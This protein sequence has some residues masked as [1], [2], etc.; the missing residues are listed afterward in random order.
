[1]FYNFALFCV[2]LI[3]SASS[4]TSE[5]A[6]E[7]A[8]WL[9]N[10]IYPSSQVAEFM[11]DTAVHRAQWIRANGT[12]PIHEICREFPR[13]VD[14]SGMVCVLT[15]NI[16]HSFKDLSSYRFDIDWPRPRNNI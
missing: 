16:T 5:K 8:E 14:T 11:R 1:M 15:G 2:D 10:N 9:K 7:L 12:K 3:S 4:I 13:L 6:V